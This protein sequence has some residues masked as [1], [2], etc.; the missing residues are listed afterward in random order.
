MAWL[1]FF[2]TF[3]AAT[4][5]QTHVSSVVPPGGTVIQDAFLTEL[6]RPEQLSFV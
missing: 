4:R 1:G 6:L 5:N 2:P 3:Y